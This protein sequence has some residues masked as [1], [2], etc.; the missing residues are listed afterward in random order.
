MPGDLPHTSPQSHTGSVNELKALDTASSEL[1]NWQHF[2]L[3]HFYYK[4]KSIPAIP[5]FGRQRHEDLE[6][7]ASLGY[8]MSLCL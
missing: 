4:I 1:L 3:F 5:A 2:T 6:F 8:T 7:G